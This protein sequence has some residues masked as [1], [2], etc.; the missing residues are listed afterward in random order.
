MVQ[1]QLFNQPPPHT[2]GSSRLLWEMREGPT[3]SWCSRGIAA[4]RTLAGCE[5]SGARDGSTGS[6]VLQK[7]LKEKAEVV[8]KR[9]GKQHVVPALRPGR[10]AVSMVVVSGVPQDSGRWGLETPVSP[11]A[12]PGLAQLGG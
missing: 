3:R 7:T 1:P 8:K 11:P 12:Q 5:T 4:T 9:L 2:T 10:S 6:G